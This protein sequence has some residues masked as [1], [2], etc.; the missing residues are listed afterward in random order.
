M[1]RNGS[2]AY[3]LPVNTWNPA[4]TGV[5]ATVTDWQALINDIA[6]AMQQSVSSDGQTAMTGN[7]AMGNNKL[8]GLSAGTATGHS[9]RWEQLFSQGTIANL[10]SATTTDIGAQN[11][12][13]LNITGTTTITG[14]GTNYNGPRYLVFAGIL[15]LTH[16]A[17][18]VC[19]GAANITTAAND[20]AIAIPISGGWQIVAYQ[21]ASGLPVSTTGLVPTGLATASGLTMSTARALI[22]TTAGTGA[23]EEATAA[24]LSA[25]AAAATETAQ[26]VSELATTAET[27][28]G[29]DGTRT[30]TP[31]GLKGAL[32]Y[33]K[34]FSSSDQT[35][36]FGSK[37]TVAHGLGAVP[38]FVQTFLKCAT[39]EYN[40]SVGDIIPYGNMDVVGVGMTTVSADSTNVVVV[41]SGTNSIRIND[42]NTPYSINQITPG[43][44][45]WV[46]RAMA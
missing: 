21:K 29:S 38:V 32:L 8:T 33:S 22:R 12:S 3:S 14:L 40:Y 24:Q 31:A 30:V 16:S 46:I 18:L 10:A 39:A 19:P 15:T 2:G 11:T 23:I 25:F 41:N 6:T 35:V 26:G 4:T 7:L 36:A 45:R 37:V 1:S 42:K 44:W 13:F 9:L 20:S 43:N 17:T 28:T 5:S 27:Q 34:T